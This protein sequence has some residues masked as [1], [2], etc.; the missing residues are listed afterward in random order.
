MTVRDAGDGSRVVEVPPEMAPGWKGR[1][2]TTKDGSYQPKAYNVRL[3]LEFDPDWQGVLS[4]CDF[5]Y[6][7]IKARK[8]PLRNGATGEW[9]DGDTADLRFWLAEHYGFEPK[10][11]DVN[12]AILGVSQSNR[13]HPVK[14][15]LNSLTW[16]G[17]QRVESWLY[18]YLKADD[19]GN[20]GK[21]KY[22]QAVGR[23]WMVAAVARVMEP[24]VKADCVM[25][26]EGSQGVGKSTALNI[27]GGDWFAD[28]HFIL[29]SNDG[30]QFLR[31][32]WI[33]ELAE[34]DAFNKAE[35]TK[36]KQF[37]GARIDRFRPSYGHYTQEF[38]RQCVIAGTTNQESYLKD[39]T[40]NRRYWPIYCSA[41][42]D[43]GGKPIPID[44]TTLA[45]D[46]DQL[47]AEAVRMYRDGVKWWPDSEDSGIFSDEQDK[48]FASDAYQTCRSDS[49]HL[50]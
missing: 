1:L 33:I 37:F 24:P 34:L 49:P 11:S 29:G 13:I 10:S 25:I 20:N 12:D 18:Q 41:Q 22:L 9:H 44:L 23:M 26:L 39:A 47:W 8:P 50:T 36:A 43:K 27:L 2:M 6:K 3:V 4:Y 30:Y 16:D 14:D 38:A 40:G 48:R 31:G 46:R 35:S 45:R 15:Y 5:S 17:T 7:I 19:G 42:L 21:A 28:S 32:V